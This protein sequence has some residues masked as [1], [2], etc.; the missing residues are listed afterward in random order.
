MCG[1]RGAGNLT[2]LNVKLKGHASCTCDAVWLRG[3][4]GG[5]VGCA[6]S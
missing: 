2:T 5:V 4:H 1:V 6:S 3:I